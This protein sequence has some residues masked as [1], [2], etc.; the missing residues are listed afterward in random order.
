MKENNAAF[1]GFTKETFQ[2]FKDISENNYKEWFDANKSVY[3]KEVLN[4]LKDLANALTVAMY[5]IDPKFDLRTHRIVSRIYRDTRFSKNK[6]PYKSR[7]WLYFE[8]PSDDCTSFPGFYIE[9]SANGYM[10][11]M[12]MYKPK[13]SVM[14]N[15]RDKV[16]YDSKEFEKESQKLLNLGFEI[17]GEEYKRPLKNDLPEYFQQWIQRKSI[18]VSLKK[19]IGKEVFNANFV[20]VLQNHI[21]S[22]VWL[23]N[24]MKD[25]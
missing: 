4:P 18:Y 22:L 12:G 6:D 5:N 17:C 20:E 25:E 19:E 24:F 3:E 13:K 23:Y 8:Q 9:F 10:I 14:D 7:M 1:T 16:T 11:D 21:N 15:F 2:F